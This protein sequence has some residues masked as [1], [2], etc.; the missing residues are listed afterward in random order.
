MRT[1]IS[2]I[3]IILACILLAVCGS[4]G[5]NANT[6]TET[7][8]PVQRASISE[9]ADTLSI[10]IHL[11]QH[12][13]IMALYTEVSAA[14]VQRSITSGLGTAGSIDYL[15]QLEFENTGKETQRA[16]EIVTQTGSHLE[17]ELPSGKRLRCRV[18]QENGGWAIDVIASPGGEI[19]LLTD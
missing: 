10:A 2:G 13:A 18:T 1:K 17:L 4:G 16:V 12:R 11:R 14:A 3:L 15:F 9:L 7:R 8:I 6:K 19:L 5:D